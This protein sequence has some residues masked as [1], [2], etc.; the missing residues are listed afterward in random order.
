MIRLI[1]QICLKAIRY[2][3]LQIAR[4]LPQERQY[5]VQEKKPCKIQ[6]NCSSSFCCEI[7]ILIID[8]LGEEVKRLVFEDCAKYEYGLIVYEVDIEHIHI[9]LEYK[10]KNSM[11]SVVKNLK[12]YTTY[13]L[14]QEYDDFISKFIYG[15]RKFWS[16]GYFACSVWQEAS[17]ESIKKYI[18]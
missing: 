14:K 12:Q 9:L 5:Y 10:P 18:F 3:N 1:F 2:Q 15:S 8:K 4:E 16:R 17:Y 11:N 13:H 7:Q 6:L